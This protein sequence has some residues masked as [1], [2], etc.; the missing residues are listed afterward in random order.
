MRVEM[1]GRPLIEARSKDVLFVATSFETGNFEC[2]D[3]D[4]TEKT[5][6]SHAPRETVA[7]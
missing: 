3:S 5:M 2:I 7:A 1:S 4:A 6:L